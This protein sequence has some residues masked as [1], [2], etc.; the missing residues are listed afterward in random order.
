MLREFF[1]ELLLNHRGKVIGVSLGFL[2]GVIVLVIGFWKTFFLC[3]CIGLG[4]WI[5]GMTDKKERFIAFLD[6]I[7]PK[8]FDN[9]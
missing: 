7:L 4:Y 2:I 9:H 8:G 5:G 3:L 6:K 1:K